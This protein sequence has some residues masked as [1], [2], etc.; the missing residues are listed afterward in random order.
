VASAAA[1]AATA[2][3]TALHFGVVQPAGVLTNLVVVP[4][5]ELVVL[6]LGLYAAAV[7]AVAPSLAA[8][9]TYVAGQA[10]GALAVLVGWLA[11]A[12][13]TFAVPPPSP[14]ELAALGA[15]ALALLVWPWRRALLAAGVALGLCLASYLVTARLLPALRS[16]AT[17]TFLDVGQGDAV[18]IEA[19]AGE[20]WLVDAGGRLFGE[21]G[22][23]PDPGEQAVWRFLA[24]RRIGTINLA[25]VSHPHPD[26]YGGLAALTEHL[27]IAELWISGDDPGDARWTAVVDALRAHG[28][29]VRV[30]GPGAV[31]TAGGARFAVLAGGADPGRSVNDNSLVVRL[32]LAGRRVLFTGDVEA[33][34]EEALASLDLAA[35]VVKVPHHGSKTSSSSAL[36]RATHPVLAVVSLGA[37]NRFGFPAPRVVAAWAAAGAVVARTDRVG[38]V[39][40]E[41]SADGALAWRVRAQ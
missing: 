36:V 24:A 16:G 32:E 22:R 40:V 8:P 4:L 3:L 14:V 9:V 18:V 20:T 29:L 10:A 6:P 7:G 2:P 25:V 17:V 19:P 11:R 13:P 39:T 1:A 12:S 23:G 33:P 38:A 41:L 30:V 15:A 31:R 26:H 21:P 5:A 37:A 27:P 28:T 34:A 35:D